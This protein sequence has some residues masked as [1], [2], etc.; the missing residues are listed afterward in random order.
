[1]TTPLF[2]HNDGEPTKTVT[3]NA[4][5]DIFAQMYSIMIGEALQA[6]Y[7]LTGEARADERMLS[8]VEYTFEKA[9]TE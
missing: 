9:R 7:T 2:I 5:L 6:G 8:L 3:L 4:S 1:V